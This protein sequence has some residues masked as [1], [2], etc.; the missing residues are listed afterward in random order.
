MVDPGVGRDA[1]DR[2]GRSRGERR[3]APVVGHGPDDQRGGV[4]QGAARIGG[5]GR[6]PVREP[7][8][9]V[10]AL[11]LPG[12]E[13]GEGVGPRRRL[14]HPEGVETGAEPEGAQLV[15]GGKP[16]DAEV[17]GGRTHEGCYRARRGSLRR[18]GRSG[19]VA[20]PP[21]GASGVPVSPLRPAGTAR[22][23]RK[24][25][26][27]ARVATA[28]E[29]VAAWRATKASSSAWASARARATSAATS[30][31][32]GGAAAPAVGGSVFVAAAFV[33][34]AVAAG[35][36]SAGAFLT[37]AVA[38]FLAGAFVIAACSVGAFLGEE[39]FAA[40]FAAGAFLAAELRRR[41]L[42]AAG[43]F[44]AVASGRR[45]LLAAAAFSVGA[46][47]VEVRFAAAFT[48]GF[49]AG[50]AGAGAASFA[51]AGLERATGLGAAVGAA[52]FA[53]GPRR[54]TS[55][56]RRVDALTAS[57][58][59]ASATLRATDTRRAV[60]RSPSVGAVTG[61]F[62]GLPGLGDDSV[63][64]GA[65]KA[66]S[67]ARRSSARIG[68]RAPASSHVGCWRRPLET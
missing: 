54:A 57:S 53:V 60:S 31:A 23:D 21:A 40:A 12:A 47:L 15:D 32:A 18:R 65:T 58:S 52:F 28:A 26:L 6:V 17:L 3:R 42:L 39:R 36:F 59:C 30:V 25:G 67:A 51:A 8:A 5:S 34:A 29:A 66:S 33:S 11:G 7:H 56:S 50:V 10:V 35:A 46:F 49:S 37:A 16:G 4:G 19:A 2:P 13:P 22:S 14:G 38:A 1:S 62:G 48:A 27:P 45:R 63:G 43:A 9:G 41:R 24:T 68:P 44:A 55:A 61:T 64:S 20:A